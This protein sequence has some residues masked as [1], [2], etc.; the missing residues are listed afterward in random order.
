MF[1]PF[2]IA[3]KNLGIFLVL[4]MLQIHY[5]IYRSE[6]CHLSPTLSFILYAKGSSKYLSPSL[7]S[8]C[9]IALC[10][11]HFNLHHWIC[12]IQ[13][14]LCWSWTLELCQHSK[15]LSLFWSTCLEVEEMAQFTRLISHMA[16]CCHHQEVPCIPRKYG[17]STLD[18]Y[19]MKLHR[20]IL[21]TLSLIKAL[22][23]YLV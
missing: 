8:F 22:L 16:L 11:D 5:F 20:S 19:L 12:S 18:L 21:L 23:P 3:L 17:L 1:Y 7:T 2:Q 4:H 13:L 6:L 9:T 10:L 15:G 14:L